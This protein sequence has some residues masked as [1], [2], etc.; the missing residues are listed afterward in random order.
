SPTGPTCARRR[1]STWVSDG[2]VGSRRGPVD[3]RDHLA[4][5]VGDVVHVAGTGH[6]PLTGVTTQLAHRLDLMVPTLHVAVG[7]VATG[8]VDRQSATWADR[9][10]FE[11]LPR[12]ADRAVPETLERDRDVHTEAVVDLDAVDPLGSEAGHRPQLLGGLAVRRV[13][14]VDEPRPQAGG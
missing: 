4:G 8:R 5:H 3:D 12:A 13:V 2:S 1:S 11:E 7:Q 10:R 9:P 14:E 6:L